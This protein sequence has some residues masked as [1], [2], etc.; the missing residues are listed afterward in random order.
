MRFANAEE[1]LKE[2]EFDDQ[3]L[4]AAIAQVRGDGLSNLEAKDFINL[5]AKANREMPT[6]LKNIVVSRSLPV[7]T[8][9][10]Y[11]MAQNEIALGA[12]FT[13][14]QLA[15]KFPALSPTQ[16]QQFL[17]A[18]NMRGSGNGST[19]L[20]SYTDTLAQAIKATAGTSNQVDPGFMATGMIGLMK[21]EFAREFF[22]RRNDTVNYG[23]YTDDQIARELMI[24]YKDNLENGKGIFERIKDK[25]GN[26]VVG[27]FS[28]FARVTRPPVV[29]S[30]NWK[31]T[32]ESID[33]DVSVLSSKPLL[34]D[35][36]DPNSWASEI[37]E[38]IRTG[39]PSWLVD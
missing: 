29:D 24:N 19:G 2:K 17:S 1:S 22:E 11:Q 27:S 26:T 31:S 16:R 30:P 3:N 4:K 13:E 18:G 37:P 39:K 9:M 8:A 21:Q 20:K 23:S 33:N 36:N 5:Y 32:I 35:I 10:Q 38:I 12:T 14:A 15:A 34:G 28:G 7:D 25:N 6:E